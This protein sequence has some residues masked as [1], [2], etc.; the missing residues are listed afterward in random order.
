MYMRICLY[1]SFSNS[2]IRPMY[3]IIQHYKYIENFSLLREEN[4][5]TKTGKKFFLPKNVM[6]ELKWHVIKIILI[7]IDLSPNMRR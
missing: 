5:W 1:R 2:L 6:S 4:T 7:L 3:S